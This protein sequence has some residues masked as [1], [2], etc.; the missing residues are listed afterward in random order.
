M[1]RK[2]LQFLLITVL[3]LTLSACNNDSSDKITIA[4]GM[5]P[6]PYLTDDVAM[7]EEWKRL[8]EADYP[9]YEIVGTPYSYSI[10]T[11]FPM[12]QSGTQ[13]TIFTT[14][15]TE[16][17]KLIRNGFV[18]DIDDELKE[19]GWYDSMD[20]QMRDTLTFN[21]LVYGVP[22]D[23]YGMGLFI[24][25]EIFAEVGLVD[26]WNNDGIYDIVGPDG[27]PR[28]PTTFEE[29]ADTSEF[30]TQTMAEYYERD[31]AG[32]VVLSSN[33]TGGWQFSNI[34]WNFGAELQVQDTSGNWM[35][36][37]DSPEAIAALQW[38]KDMKWNKEALPEDSSLSY[39][40]WFNFIGTGRAAMAFAGNDAISLPITNFG[41]D[42]NS[43]AFVPMPAGPNGDQYSLFGGTPYMFSSQAT[44][45]EVLGALR[46][47]EY[48]GR[49]PE[50]S[51]VSVQS[52]ILGMETA[53]QKGMPILPS[54][55]AW[56]NESYLTQVKSIEATY[57]NIETANF[58][59]FFDE[60]LTMRKPEVPYYS[61]EMYEILDS[62]IQNVLTNQ[63]ANPSALLTSA[64]EQFQTQY[65][66]NV[67]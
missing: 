27:E 50:T 34:A 32:L 53:T 46:F 40:D 30:I 51:D 31:V 29:L 42:R 1:K 10:D 63:N 2:L 56:Q 38:I 28:Y 17:E 59:D 20:T 66:N 4:V 52:M 15:F 24:N 14:W 45:E 19:L 61:Q 26:D 57:V 5:W 64:N 7:Y 55:Y 11:F 60:I 41:M 58:D 3:I 21:D 33:N 16:P 44:D 9:E 43:I 25:L 54:I 13:P 23:G 37:L 62:V 67:E 12:A 6:E 18:R 35:S 36:N 49:S 39:S 47:L 22:R 8:F 48:I 65:M